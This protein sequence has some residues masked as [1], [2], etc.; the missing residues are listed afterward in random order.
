M[1]NWRWPLYLTILSSSLLKD[2]L[3]L[4]LWVNYLMRFTF[5]I[6]L[7]SIFLTCVFYRLL[8]DFKVNN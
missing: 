7:F 6:L 4:C 8:P 5:M 2:F 1:V 3:H